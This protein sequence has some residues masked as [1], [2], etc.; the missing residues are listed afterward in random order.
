MILDYVANCKKQKN[1]LAYNTLCSK[2]PIRSWNFGSIT[3]KRV[4]GFK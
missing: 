1:N 2:M 4:S 3:F